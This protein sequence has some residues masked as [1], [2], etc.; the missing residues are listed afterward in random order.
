[1]TKEDRLTNVISR[2]LVDERIGIIHK[3]RERRSTHDYSGLY[4]FV[5]IAAHPMAMPTDLHAV[6]G[7]GDAQR[8][9]ARAAAIGEAVERYCLGIITERESD[10]S[11]IE[12]K[13]DA[14]CSFTDLCWFLDEQYSAESFQLDKPEPSWEYRWSTGI[15]LCSDS[16]ASLPSSLVYLP[17]QPLSG[18]RVTTFQTSVGTSCGRSFEDAAARAVL[19][20]IERDSLTIC[21]ESKVAFP[22]VDQKAV[23]RVAKDLFSQMPISL[24][25]FDL[26]SDLGI[27]VL[28]A[29]AMAEEGGPAIAIGTA[30]NINPHVA[31]RRAIA[32]SIT[33]WRS[34]QFLILDQSLDIDEVELTM[35]SGA[36]LPAHSWYYAFPKARTHFDFLLESKIPE[37]LVEDCGQIPMHLWNAPCTKG[38]LAICREQLSAV[39]HD[40]V[41]FD[42]TL[43]DIEQVGLYVVRAVAP[44][45]VRPTI[46]LTGRHL[47]NPRIRMI[48]WRLNYCP[49][50]VPIASLLTNVA[51]SP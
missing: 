33:S 35:L 42:L 32:E 28:L 23:D 3:L 1:M 38:A 12:E 41:L 19:E 31:L 11:R 49:H 47:A 18:E 25:A 21:W 43:A 17:Y 22:P 14:A 51:P 13:S 8:V 20:L 46:S 27:P 10:L 26:S 44:S 4:D 36:N 29:V 48:P 6:Y 37:R 45:L 24:R 34:T 50:P 39:G 5:S 2:Y 16:L 9:S 15:S 40:A 30:A 7:G